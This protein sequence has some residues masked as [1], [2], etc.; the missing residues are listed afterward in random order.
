M[1][2]YRGLDGHLYMRG[3]LGTVL[4]RSEERIEQPKPE[5]HVM[6]RL[7]K[8]IYTV[9]AE[10]NQEHLLKLVR[11]WDER[12]KGGRITGV[13]QMAPSSIELFKIYKRDN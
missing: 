9:W 12:L 6:L 13:L 10:T 7:R 1:D 2:I 4:W 8:G 11:R 5:A 3:L